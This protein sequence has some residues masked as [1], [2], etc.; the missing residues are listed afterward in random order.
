MRTRSANLAAFL[1]AATALAFTAPKVTAADAARPA[2]AP[3]QQPAAPGSRAIGQRFAYGGSPDAPGGLGATVPYKSAKEEYEALKARARGGRKLTAAQLP[4]WSGVWEVSP[5]SGTF[6]FDPSLSRDADTYGPQ[7]PAAHEFYMK[8]MKNLEKNIEWDPLSYCLASGFPRIMAEGFL[9][10]F[11][12]TP[13]VV[14]IIAETQTEVRRVYTD[15]RPHL[16][17]DEAFPMWEGDSIGFWDGEGPNAKLVVW[18]TH[19]RPGIYHR[20]GPRY[21][22]KLQAVEQIWMTDPDHIKVE[23]TVYDPVDLTRPWHVSRGFV[24]N[25]TPGVRIADQWVCAENNNVVKTDVGSSD[26]VLPGEQGYKDPGVIGDPNKNV[27]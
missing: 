9:H 11:A 7:S 8:T 2:A 13:N 14:Y 16:A 5:P 24:R 26:F 4:D 21:S 25:K 20:N 19:V 3:A 17:E 27:K 1:I 23:M 12:I 10:D 22:D 6:N 18:T 15:G